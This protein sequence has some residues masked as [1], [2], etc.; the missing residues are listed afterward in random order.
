MFATAVSAKLLQLQRRWRRTRE[1]RHRAPSPPSEE[2]VLLREITGPFCA[3]TGVPGMR[4]LSSMMADEA[5]SPVRLGTPKPEPKPEPEL[6]PPESRKRT[7]KSLFRR[8]RASKPQPERKR[9]SKGDIGMPTDFRHPQHMGFDAESQEVQVT[10]GDEDGPLVAAFL[11]TLG[12]NAGDTNR[13]IVMDFIRNH[14]GMGRLR[15]ELKGGAPLISEIPEVPTFAPPP[16]LLPP[17]P[18]AAA[19]P[20]PAAVAVPAAAAL[21]PAPVAALPPAAAPAAP[22]APVAALPQGN[23]ILSTFVPQKI[24]TQVLVQDQYHAYALRLVQTLLN[25]EQTGI[26]Y[27]TLSFQLPSD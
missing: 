27:A 24:Q 9:L 23:S 17:A 14:G 7:L 3:N 16:V 2:A 6:A 26:L 20:A 11:Q 10:G 12:V 4:R 19:P 15:E 21:P 1:K 8:R 25:I 22:P 18:S 5:T 13:K